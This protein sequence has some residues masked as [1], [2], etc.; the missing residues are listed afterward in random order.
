M[1]YL[2]ENI[3]VIFSIILSFIFLSCGASHHLSSNTNYKDENFNYH[4]L[5]KNGMIIAG[6]SIIIKPQG[7]FLT[8]IF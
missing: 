3:T 8:S 6:I 2:K 7:Y 4:L 1:K 5:K